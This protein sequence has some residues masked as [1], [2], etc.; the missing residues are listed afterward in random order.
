MAELK[1]KPSDISVS[2][3]IAD[4]EHDG[5]RQDA[6]ALLSLFQCITRQEPVL[7]GGRIIG[8][9]QY[10]YKTDAGQEGDWPVT[11]FAIAKQRLTIYIMLGFGPYQHFLDQL[12]KYKTGKSCLYINKLED[13][14]LEVLNNL[15]Q[16]SYRDMLKK[17]SC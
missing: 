14:D 5:K 8:F 13:I 17:Y 3:Y 10:H 11:G 16:M 12:G 4:I 9:N 6:E 2:S 15:I 7:W 1:T